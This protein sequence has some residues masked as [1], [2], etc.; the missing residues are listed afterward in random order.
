MRCVVGPLPLAVGV[1]KD[2]SGCLGKLTIAK[3]GISVVDSEAL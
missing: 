1:G 2:G 3:T